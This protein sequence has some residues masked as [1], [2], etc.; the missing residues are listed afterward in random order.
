MYSVGRGVAL[1]PKPSAFFF[2]FGN[3][4]IEPGDLLSQ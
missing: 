3:E 4:E 1:K 2:L